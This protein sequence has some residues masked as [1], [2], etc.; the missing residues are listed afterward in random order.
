[1]VHLQ[2]VS[3]RVDL[4]VGEKAGRSQLNSTGKFS[5]LAK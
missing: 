3:Q 1:M 5:E 2:A 4:Q